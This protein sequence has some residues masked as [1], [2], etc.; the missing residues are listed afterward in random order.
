MKKNSETIFITRYNKLNPEQKKAVDAIEG[1]VL[2]IAGP[3]SG[4]TEILSLRVAN[5]LEKTDT[6]PGSILC[7][8]FTD[9]ASLN[10]R[11]RLA[12]LI[13][14]AAYRVQI[15]TFHSFC[16]YV[17]AR[18]PEYFFGSADFNPADDVT[19]LE[20]ISTIFRTLSHENPL[21]S[22]HPD[23]GFVFLRPTLKSISDLKRAGMSPGEF[24]QVVLHNETILGLLNPL[25]ARMLPERI[26][27][28]EIST[29]QRLYTAMSQV[30]C[31]P[32]PLLHIQCLRDTTTAALNVALST[33]EESGT[34]TPLSD[35]KKE[36][37]TRDV[38]GNFVLKDTE[39]APKMRALA[40][41]YD[42][43]QKEMYTEGYFDFDDMILE[44]IQAVEKNPILALELQESFQYILVDEFQDTNDAQMRLI[45]ALTGAEVHEGRPNVMAVGD[46]DQSIYKFQGAEVANIISFKK[47]FRNPDVIT[48]TTNYR[49]TPEILDISEKVINQGVRGLKSLLPEIEKTITAGNTNL[50]TGRVYFKSFE[51]ELHEYDF[52]AKEIFRLI[53]EGQLP[54]QIA[55]IARTHKGLQNIV[56]YF[57]ALGIDVRY[58]KRHDVLRDELIREIIT[59]IKFVST[60]GRGNMD[61]AD[62]YMPEILSFPFWKISRKLVWEISLTARTTV[63]HSWIATMQSHENSSVRD[64]AD[65]LIDVGIRS[66]S[67]PLE[68]VIDVLIGSEVLLVSDSE[69]NEDNEEGEREESRKENKE[70]DKVT[71]TPVFHSPFR[72]YYFSQETFTERKPEYI[73]FLSSLKVFIGALREYRQGKVLSVGDC[74]SFVEVHEKNNMELLDQSPFVGGKHAVSFLT[75]HKAKGL[76]FDVVFILSAND[77]IWSGRGIP[78]KLP[79]PKNITARPSADSIDDKIRLLYVAL[80]R[81]RHTLYV[82]HY[83]RRE[84]GRAV[85][86][87]EFLSPFSHQIEKSENIF[88]PHPIEVHVNSLVALPFTGD[89]E[90]MLHSTLS[91]YCMSVT[92]LNNFLDVSRAGPHVFLE[93]NL[94]RF[95]QAK[96]PSNVYG[97]SMHSSLQY[98]Y[99]YFRRETTLPPVDQVLTF[100]EKSLKS[101]RLHPTD[102]LVQVERGRQALALYIKTHADD[103][104]SEDRIETDFKHQGVVLDSETGMACIQPVHITGKIDKMRIEGS[105]I[106]VTDWKTGK[107]KTSWEGKSLEEKIQLYSYRR[108]LLFYA[109]LIAGSK[110]FSDFGVSRGN[111]EFLEPVNNTFLALSLEIESSEISR[112]KSLIIA[113]YCKIV[114]LDFPSTEKYS[115]D[116]AGCIEFENDLI[117]GKI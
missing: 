11:E 74:V 26:T 5:I 10:M 103:I 97:T 102:H 107:P 14:T 109:I 22:E 7:L 9:S 72:Q 57:K 44:V 6:A 101:G 69:D 36:N 55:V 29:L 96:T 64:I 31:L 82:T 43:Y 47:N 46:D 63:S 90:S 95:P 115:P 16:T 89:E 8:T 93:Q 71:S 70:E 38:S 40:D 17:I 76:E 108:Q 48:L 83:E 105:E 113:V 27:K 67:L 23:Q 24:R 65:F 75:A 32:L 39:R 4:K 106:V 53:K 84:D 15:H 21:R 54:E 68:R 2:V 28:K 112:L 99:T 116:F 77:E 52:I 81:A 13:G 51:T 3:G 37:I 88:D 20:I 42:A 110:D 87:L 50:P 30:P 12:G 66:Q 59:L 62:E 35:W 18:Y 111:L 104:R 79:F 41:M 61:E 1:P 85:L 34:S 94:L 56:P 58:E 19:R 98:I 114:A 49:S 91:E 60:I 73:S 86:P 25:V 92:H 80:T 78:D 33:A 117:E 45:L 100:F